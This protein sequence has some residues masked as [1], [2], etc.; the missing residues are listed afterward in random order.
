[1]TDILLPNQED[2]RSGPWYN[3]YQIGIFGFKPDEITESVEGTG[4]VDYGDRGAQLSA[5]G[6]GGEKTRLRVWQP[7]AKR[8]SWP[9]NGIYTGK[10][11][12]TIGVQ[13]S[14]SDAVASGTLYLGIINTSRDSI[15]FKWED[16]GL[17]PFI[18][19]IE[20]PEMSSRRGQY[21][22]S[23]L[24]DAVVDETI[25]RANN[26]NTIKEYTMNESLGQGWSAGFNVVAEADEDG[27][28]SEKENGNYI[29]SMRFDYMESQNVEV[30]VL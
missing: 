11:R 26:G 18:N 15:G 6:D 14:E 13:V 20:G 23:I 10:F 24:H 1:M 7:T 17:A 30:D 3:L 16:G 9:H 25:F 2:V 28:Y 12:Q 22:L 8:S 4:S 21:Q 19:D 29:Y 5:G 27:E